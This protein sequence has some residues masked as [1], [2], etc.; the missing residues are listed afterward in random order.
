MAK[1]LSIND[2]CHQA[3]IILAEAVG[4]KFAGS[5]DFEV[6]MKD[7]GIGAVH[8]TRRSEMR[9]PEDPAPDKKF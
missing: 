1:R 9:P 2:F 8:V 4:E 3:A 5:F 7:G 6:H